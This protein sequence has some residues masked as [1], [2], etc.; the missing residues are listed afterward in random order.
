MVSQISSKFK[1]TWFLKKLRKQTDESDY[2]KI[3][4]KRVSG[5]GWVSKI[6]LESLKL[7]NKKKLKNESNI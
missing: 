2:K 4:V 5:K 7:N 1:D 3:F 6:Y